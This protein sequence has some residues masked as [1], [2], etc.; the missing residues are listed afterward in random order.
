MKFS[1]NVKKN[2]FLNNMIESEIA[3]KLNIYI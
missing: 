1:K 2:Y 3:K